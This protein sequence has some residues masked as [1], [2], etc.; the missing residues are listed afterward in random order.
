MDDALSTYAAHSP[1]T[2]PRR[3]AGLYDNL[4]TTLPE[5]CHV[6]Q[7]LLLHYREG[8]MYGVEVPPER[9]DRDEARFV[10]AMLEKLLA[11]DDRPLA[12]ARPPERRLVG[13][14]R[15]F[16]VLLCSLLRH[17]G[18]PARVRYGFSLYFTPTLGCDHVVTEYWDRESA[19]W[20]LVDPQQDALHREMNGLQ[21]DPHDV[22]RD[23]FLSAGRTWQ[24]ARGGLI[25]ARRFGYDRDLAGSWVVQQYLVHDL[26]ALNKLELL[27][28]DL[29]G[30]GYVAPGSEPTDGEAAL[31]DEAARLAQAD[32]LSALR[33]LYETHHGLR[34]PETF[35]SLSLTQAWREVGL[36]TN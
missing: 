14:C 35:P 33:R 28:G 11:Y 16:A 12:E 17:R 2:D 24:L 4:P 18:V 9:T 29:W 7:G 27:I 26:A 13:C 1:V 5:L 25:D 15:D 20:L 34:V 22:P 8:E 19:R 21:F 32:D 31:L 36:G 23:W 3:L 10:L 30:L 6:V